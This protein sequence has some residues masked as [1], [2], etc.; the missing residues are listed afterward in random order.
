M[1]RSLA[2]IVVQRHSAA[3]KPAKPSKT[4]Q[5]VLL[6]LLPIPMC[7]RPPNRSTQ[8]PSLRVS[9]GQVSCFFGGGGHGTGGGGGQGVSVGGGFGTIVGG[10][11]WGVGGGFGTYGGGVTTTGGFGTY[12]GDTT[13]GF[14]TNGGETTGGF[15]T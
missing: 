2:L 9:I 14:G 1:F 11:G 8:A 10:A 7:T 6:T 15:G 5:H 13:G 12:G 4:G 3:S